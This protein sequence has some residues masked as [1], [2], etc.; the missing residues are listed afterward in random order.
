M[1]KDLVSVIFPTMNRKEDAIKCI[2]SIKN[3][4]YKPIEIIIVDNCSTDGTSE[5]IK[6]MHPDVILIESKVN[7]GVPIANNQCVKKSK[8]EFILRLDDDVLLEKHLIEKM[9][10]TLKDDSK[11]GGVSCLYYYTEKP[12]ICRSSGASFNLFTAKTRFY[13]RDK[14]Y[15]LEEGLIEREVIGGILLMKRELYDEIGGF[16]EEYFLSYDD[17]DLCFKIR[18]A[19]YKLVTIKSSMIYHKKGGGLIQKESS[20]RVYFNNRNQIIFMKRHAGWRN[21][22]F[23]P[24]LFIV[25]YPVKSLRFLFKGN[26]QAVKSL[27]KGVFDGIFNE[28]VFVYTKEGKQIPYPKE[29]ENE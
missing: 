19:G 25:L 18:K 17:V 1:K 15:K 7:L 12:N 9:V 13:D 28:K 6:K 4:T 21:L 5:E 3:S 8:G 20:Q 11:I 2:N 24:Y 23:F 27:T 22:F 26:I 29:I 10:K 16:A 14:E